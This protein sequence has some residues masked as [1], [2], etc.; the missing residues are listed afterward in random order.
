MDNYSSSLSAFFLS[1]CFLGVGIAAI[2]VR[3]LI[4]QQKR[5]LRAMEDR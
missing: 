2:S 5:A 3:P 4:A 1:F